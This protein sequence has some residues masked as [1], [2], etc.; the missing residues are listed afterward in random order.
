MLSSNLT[1][2]IG[3]QIRLITNSG[4]QVKGNLTNNDNTVIT[5]LGGATLGNGTYPL[6]TYLGTLSGYPNSTPAI[7]NG[8]VTGVAFVSTATPNQVNL[9]VATARTPAIS[10]ISVAGP[11]LNLNATNG[12]PGNSYAL[13]ASTNLALPLLQWTPVVL[14]GIFDGSGNANVNLQI[15][16]TLGSNSPQQ[17]F[18]IQMPGP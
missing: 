17:F 18:R 11:A 13:L 6:M 1:L 5:D 2:A 14:H 9:V 12:I 16:N 3:G 15:T 7:V 8:S 10:S 4:F